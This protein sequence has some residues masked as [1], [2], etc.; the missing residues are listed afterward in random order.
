MLVRAYSLV[1][2]LVVLGCGPPDSGNSCAEWTAGEYAAHKSAI[3]G[4]CTWQVAPER[5]AACDGDAAWSWRQCTHE[6][7]FYART[8]TPE[9][10]CRQCYH[11]WTW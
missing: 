3:L 8:E 4:D 11:H 2:L 10:K 5:L 7:I 6:T 1:A 9:G